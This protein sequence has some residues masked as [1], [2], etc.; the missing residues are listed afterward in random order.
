MPVA[1]ATVTVP[2]IYEK[3]P[4]LCPKKLIHELRFKN[5]IFVREIQFMIATIHLKQ[6]VYS[7]EASLLCYQKMVGY[8]FSF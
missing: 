4:L 3:T 5:L 1:N 7:C 8:E 6:T 2:N